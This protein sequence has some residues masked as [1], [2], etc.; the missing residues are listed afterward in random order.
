MPG[1]IEVGLQ[2]RDNAGGQKTRQML[3]GQDQGQCLRN[4]Q[5]RQIEVLRILLPTPAEGL[6]TIIHR[7]RK[8]PG[9]FVEITLYRPFGDL[10]TFTTQ[11]LIDCLR[12]FLLRA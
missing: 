9:Q 10:K 3:F 11:R 5:P 7:Q 2:L 8:N 12:R 1:G 4:R 6:L